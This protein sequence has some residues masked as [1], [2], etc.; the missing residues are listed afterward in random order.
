MNA[1]EKTYAMALAALLL[2]GLSTAWAGYNAT[3]SISITTSSED[4]ATVYCKTQT[5]Q[6]S[7]LKKNVWFYKNL[8]TV[9]TINDTQ[10]SAIYVTVGV[11]GMAD[12]ADDFKALDFNITLKDVTNDRII[13][14]G[15]ISLEGG[16]STV[17]LN[18]TSLSNTPDLTV[19]V[20][21]GGRPA[22][23]GSSVNIQ[24]YCAVEPA[25]VVT[26]P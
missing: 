10:V 2:V 13:A 19:D 16:V 21:V 12:L 6:L 26:P 24:M 22:K 9:F 4:F 20:S 7:N 14:Q 25:V 8:G 11:I 15:V 3:S 5:I 17:L 18:A 1:K 23:T